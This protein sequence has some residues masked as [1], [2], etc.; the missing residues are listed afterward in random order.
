[1]E[2]LGIDIG[3]SGIKGAIV[4][5][6]TGEL[7]TERFR[8][9]TPQPSTPEALAQTVKKVVNHFQWKSDVGCT[10]PSV[11]Y[12]GKCYTASNISKEWIGVQIDELF[13]EYCNGIPFHVGND[14]DFAGVAE[15]SIGAGKGKDGK[16]MIITI[17][18]GIG[19]GAFFNG[20]LIPNI[21]LGHILYKKDRIIEKYVADSA[22]KRDELSLKKWAKRFDFFL[23]YIMKIFNP[24][25]FII[26]G[27]LSRK[28]VKFKKHLTIDIP[29][30]A[31]KFENNA[32]IIGAAMFAHQNRK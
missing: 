31:A 14:A 16:V 15:M 17:G 11:V 20:E 2:V 26:G 1:M 22:R 4:D 6:E 27:G 12:K 13:S 19:T 24:D 28:F 5:T 25:H 10:F 18:T 32:G 23:N 3:G 8:I 30:E 21:E 9:P 7:H 29:I